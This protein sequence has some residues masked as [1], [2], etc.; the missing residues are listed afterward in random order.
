MDKTRSLHM[1]SK[2]FHLLLSFFA[3][4]A[5]GHTQESAEPMR[6]LITCGD[7]QVII[8]DLNQ[9]KD[10]VPHV[11]WRWKA[12]EA[13]DLPD[14]YRTEYFR[15]LDECKPIENGQKLLVTSS[16]GGVAIIDVESKRTLF[17]AL[18]GNAHSAALLPDGR[19]VVAA[20]TNDKGNRLALFDMKQPEKQLFKD[21]LHS[22]HG[23]VWDAERELLYALGYDE[24]RTYT[25]ADWDTDFPKLKRQKSWEIPGKS[26]H[27]L[28]SVPSDTDQLLL[29]EHESAWIFNKEKEKFRVYVPLRNKGD[30]KSVSFHSITGEMAYV[31]AEISWWSHRVYLTDTE[32]WRTGPHRWISFPGVDL[33]KVR[34]MPIMNQN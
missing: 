20:S 1:N 31:Q 22:G 2:L 24:L 14:A 19:V 18:V 8:F 10:T 32:K 15:T 16:S 25:L 21:S 5:I 17:Y 12:S 3:A 30:V 4:M 9:S 26:G 27:D 28:T 34:W 7:N 23:V 29:T 13:F 33:Y 6:H 11:V